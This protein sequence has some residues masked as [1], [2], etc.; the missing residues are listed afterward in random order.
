MKILDFLGEGCII[1]DISADSK[2]E[3]LVRLVEK[4]V[5]R[6]PSLTL[7]KVLAVIKEREQLGSTGIGGGVAIPH[8]KLADLGR[9]LII[10]GR[11]REGVPFEAVDNR[12]V[13]IV[14]L[15][16]AP[17]DSATVYLKLLA[18]V[19]RLLKTPGVYEQILD[20]ADEASV[21]KVIAEVDGRL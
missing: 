16:L 10:V 8:G 1:P 2:D 6:E 20:A 3:A 12:P 15:L 14:V 21:L 13:H 9:V 4:S 5:E 11:S 19:S 17:D 7:E 18:R